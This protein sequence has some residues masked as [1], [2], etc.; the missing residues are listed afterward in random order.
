MH[1]LNFE[2]STNGSFHD[3]FRFSIHGVDKNTYNDEDNTLKYHKTLMD[4]QNCCICS[5][6]TIMNCYFWLI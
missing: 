1:Q 4:E 3:Y 2:K 5:R 6:E